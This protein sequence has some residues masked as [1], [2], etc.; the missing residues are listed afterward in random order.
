MRLEAEARLEQ[1]P[2]INTSE[3]SA[4]SLLHEIQ[5]HQIE[6]EMQ[7]EQ[8]RYIQIALEESRDRYL[9]L[10]ESAPVAYITL[11]LSGQ[12]AE[13]NRTACTLLGES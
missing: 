2:A 5:V 3:H 7:N 12:I 13:A 8:L 6:L 10:Y 1:L 4:K 11:G 9:Y